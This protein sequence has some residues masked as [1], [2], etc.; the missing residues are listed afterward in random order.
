MDGPGERLE[1]CPQ[2][3]LT[4]QLADQL[5]ALEAAGQIGHQRHVLQ[6][7]G[8]RVGWPIRALK[9]LDDAN[10]RAVL[11]LLDG[12]Q[13]HQ[14][15]GVI[16]R[17]RL[18]LLGGA[19]RAVWRK[20]HRLAGRE[21]HP[22]QGIVAG[23]GHLGRVEADLLHVDLELLLQVALRCTN[24]H[25]TGGGGQ[26]LQEP[27]KQFAIKSRGSQ[28][29][30]AETGDVVQSLAETAALLL[31][32]L[33][34][35]AGIGDSAH[36]RNSS[37]GRVRQSLAYPELFPR[38]KRSG[39][40]RCFPSA[41]ARGMLHGKVGRIVKDSRNGPTVYNTRRTPPVSLKSTTMF[42]RIVGLRQHDVGD[43][44]PN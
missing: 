3:L 28:P 37:R 40:T 16:A 33:R 10:D 41:T 19:H 13:Q 38:C 7:A 43:G 8:N 27:L 21:R 9:D 32:H 42:K 4:D 14:E 15:A 12:H 20:M 36:V 31:D 5:V 39:V 29:A 1:R 23:T 24:P 11:A 18:T 30:L 35:G 17:G 44:P 26:R 25:G 2:L 22:K 34:S 6:E